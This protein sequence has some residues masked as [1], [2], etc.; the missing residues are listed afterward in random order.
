MST[1]R[2]A[3]FGSARTA[4][5]RLD[6]GQPGHV[7]VGDQHVEGAGLEQRQRDGAIVRLL[8]VLVA[9][10]LKDLP[11]DFAHRREVIHD[12]KSVIGIHGSA[13]L[14]ASDIRDTRIGNT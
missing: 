6:T 1:G 4:R 12:Q 2:L 7:P 11:D 3:S 9:D 13:G 14:N 5:S 10:F 8:D